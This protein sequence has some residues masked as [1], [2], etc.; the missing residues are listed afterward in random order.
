MM[1]ALLLLAVTAGVA[2]AAPSPSEVLR[3]PDRLSQRVI[4]VRRGAAGL[5]PSTTGIDRAYDHSAMVLSLPLY[6]ER[7]DVVRVVADTDDARLLVW[8]RRGDLGW[9]VARA[10]RITGRGEVGVWA[11]PG[12]P[13]AVTGD[14]KRVAVRLIGDGIVVDGTIAR[15]A[16]I[17]EHVPRPANDRGDHTT[18][19]P[20]L[21]NPDG[22]ALVV[23]GGP[24][25]VRVIDRGPNDWALVEHTHGFVRVVGWVRERALDPELSSIEGFGTFS[26]FGMSDTA[27][28]DVDAG[29]CMFTADGAVV[30]VQLARS[31]RYAYARD[32]GAWEVYVNTSWGLAQ[33]IVIDRS[34]GTGPAKWTPCP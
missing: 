10:T 29:A 33:A 19:E 31:T 5:T 7:A 17:R 22:P 1:R 21:R 12:A 6:E 13:L 25:S 23:P 32:G 11:L 24:L 27:R 28:V 16:L 26:G 18:S 14:G 4:A 30:G 9:T 3:A 15:S 20:I 8:I 34:G 2:A